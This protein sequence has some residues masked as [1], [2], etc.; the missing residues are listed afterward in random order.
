MKV[1][2]SEIRSKFQIDFLNKNS[3]EI[4]MKLIWSLLLFQIYVLNMAINCDVSTRHRNICDKKI[5]PKSKFL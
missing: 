3:K 2:T 5:K 1:R 4:I